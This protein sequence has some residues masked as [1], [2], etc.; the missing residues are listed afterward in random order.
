MFEYYGVELSRDVMGTIKQSLSFTTL[1]ECDL[2][3]M[4]V[5]TKTSPMSE[6]VNQNKP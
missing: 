5:G 2:G 6:M 1:S 3:L 4:K